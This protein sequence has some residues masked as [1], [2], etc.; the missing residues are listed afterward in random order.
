MA[1]LTITSIRVTDSTQYQLLPFGATI[2]AGEVVYIDTSDQLCKLADC[3]NTQ[4]AALAKG[5]AITSGINGGYGL[6]ATAGN[7]VLVG[8]TMVAGDSQ[9]L[10]GTPGAI[11]QDVDFA[12]GDWIT[13]IGRAVSA[14]EIK[15]DIKAFGIQVA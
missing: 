3:D 4:A 2:A 14:T 12:S 9:V 10:S 6:V 15:I 13:Q 1:D 5:V 7:L 8:S 11:Q